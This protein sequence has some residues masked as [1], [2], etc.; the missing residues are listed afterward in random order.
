[1]QSSTDLRHGLLLVQ[2]SATKLTILRYLVHKTVSWVL[3]GI[4]LMFLGIELSQAI[5][6]PR[7]HTCPISAACPGS[8]DFNT[9]NSLQLLQAFMGYWLKAGIMIS[10]IGILKLSAY[11]AWFILMHEGNTVKNLDLNLGAIRGS[12]NDA[13]FL[14]FRRNNRLLSVFVFALLGIGAA[15]SLTSSLSIDKEPQTQL[16]TFFYNVTSEL[17]NSSANF[18]NN[19]GQLKATQKVIGWALDG[20]KSH[21]GALRGSLVVPDA[22]SAQASKAIPGGPTM[23]GHFECTGLDNYTTSGAGGEKKWTILVGGTAFSA[24]ANMTLSV[25][26]SKIGTAVASY[27]WASNTTGLIPNATT[28]SDGGMN[29]ALCTHWLEMEPEAPRMKGVDYLDPSQPLTSGCKSKDSNV[30][31]ADSVNN[32]ILNWWGGLGSVFWHIT[33]RGGVLGPVPSATDAERYCALTQELWKETAVSMLDGIMRTAPRAGRGMQD[34]HAV[35]EG[36]SKRRWWVHA[37][38][39]AATV[40]AYLVGLL[41][42]CV[43]SRGEA[44]LKE[45]DLGEVIQA[46]QT[47]HIHDLVFT[48]RLKKEPII[49]HPESGFT[50]RLPH[51]STLQNNV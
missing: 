3:A 39:P 16:A 34:L 5:I 24:N 47:D 18:L 51:V 35:V 25:S 33:C 26:I 29:I 6:L 10:S 21:D 32:A 8:Y 43:L 9:G 48:G 42:T 23:T 31:V 41:Y 37:T 15:I 17:P 14:L 49:Y 44:V 22:R 11:Q 30:C 28:T 36:V 50:G 46:A 4:L 12:L 20:D 7:L 2:H 27:V 19:D 13:T 45:L 38:I 40:V 1:M